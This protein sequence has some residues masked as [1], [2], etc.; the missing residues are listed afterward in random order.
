MPIVGWGKSSLLNAIMEKCIHDPASA[1]G[2]VGERRVLV[3][4]AD[5]NEDIIIEGVGQI[6]ACLVRGPSGDMRQGSEVERVPDYGG[7]LERLAG[8]RGQAG[9][10]GDD[11]IDDVVSRVALS[12]G[13]KVPMEPAALPI[14][15]KQA[16]PAQVS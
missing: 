5:G 1:F 16:I 3:V 15:Q 7:E 14:E 13:L 8:R 2:I 12:D 6:G 4:V 11:Q 10:P 9:D